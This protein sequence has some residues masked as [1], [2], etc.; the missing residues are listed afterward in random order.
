MKKIFTKIILTALSLFFFTNLPETK[1]QVYDKL[2]MNLLGTYDNPTIPPE[3]VYGIRYNG[4][5]GWS[6]TVGQEFAILGGGD[7][8]YFVD[9]TNPANPLLKDFVPGV[10]DSCIW[11]ELKTYLNYAYMVSDDYSPNSFMI[12]DLSYLP[13]SVH[14]VHNGTNI[15]ERSH[16]IFIDGNKLYCAS[17]KGGAVGNGGTSMAVFSLANPA[18]P[19]LLRRL[20]QDYPAIGSVHDMFVRNDT[21]YASCGWDGLFIYKFNSNNT[22]TQIGSLTTYPDQGY[23]HMIGLTDNGDVMVM[24]DEVPN[25]L[26][27][28]VVDVSTVSNPQV[29]SMFKSSLGDTPHNPFILGNDY[30]ICANYQDGVQIYKITNPV[31]PVRTGYFDTHW[32]TPMGN[33][34]YGYLGCWGAYPYLPSGI[35]LASDMQNGLYVLDA[36]VALG[37]G[38]NELPDNSNAVNAY[39]NNLENSF[40]LSFNLLSSQNVKVEITDMTGRAVYS[41]QKDFAAGKFNFN[42]PAAQ[43][44]SGIYVVAVVSDK[45]NL[46]EMVCKQD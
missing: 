4:I 38:V 23:N 5:W 21:I 2:N 27:I 11:R 12:A 31:L 45:L 16:T 6:N 26:A 13:D 33:T 24:M 25:Q 19:V 29:V 20:N 46:T 35:I 18:A 9:V 28:K 37:V 32:Q 17:P 43:F 30:A 40:Q 36:T 41:L 7:G 14:L 39:Y 22:F 10:R 34:S 8:V 42:V 3:P 44:A 1:A 15:L